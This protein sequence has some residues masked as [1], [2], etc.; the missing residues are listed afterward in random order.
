MNTLN[1]LRQAGQRGRILDV[2]GDDAVAVRLMEMGLTDGAEIEL[3]G[4]APLGDPVEFLIR[5]Y[6]LSL[7]KAEAS[8]VMIELT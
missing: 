8:R 5:G 4:F 6:R 7:R 3:I 2:T 1:D